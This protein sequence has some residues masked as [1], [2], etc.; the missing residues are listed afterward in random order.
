MP[1][2]KASTDHSVRL[3]TALTWTP[4]KVPESLASARRLLLVGHVSEITE[5]VSDN[6][7]RHVVRTHFSLVS[8]SLLNLVHPDTVVSPLIQPGWDCVDLACKLH[9]NGFIGR[10]VID[11]MPIPSVEMVRR[12]IIGL[13]PGISVAMLIRA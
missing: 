8:P 12:E 13:C 2:K 10:L 6:V 5:L 4:T 11:A 1:G 7:L 9:E 3:D